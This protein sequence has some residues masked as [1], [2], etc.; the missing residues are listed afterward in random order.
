MEETGYD[1]GF[2]ELTPSNVIPENTASDTQVLCVQ[3]VDLENMFREI[4]ILQRENLE[5]KSK[6]DSMLKQQTYLIKVLED[7]H[8][9]VGMLT[10]TDVQVSL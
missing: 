6:C 7:I 8:L 9:Q 5:I 3:T 10:A 1:Y 2:P 4:S